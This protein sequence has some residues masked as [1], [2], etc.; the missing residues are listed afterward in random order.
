VEFRGLPAGLSRALAMEHIILPRNRHE[1]IQ[2]LTV[3]RG[4]FAQ[5]RG[6]CVPGQGATLAARP[7]RVS[8]I[9]Y[10]DHGLAV[11]MSGA[12]FFLEQGKETPMR[13]TPF[14]IAAASML[15]MGAGFAY[16]QS[17]TTETTTW[18]NADGTVLR[19]ESTT[20]HY[21]AYVDPALRPDVGIQLPG[22]VALYP[23]P[24]TVV[25]PEAQS[26]GYAIVN[27]QPVVV[28]RTTRR[29]VHTWE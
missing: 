29:V 24:R 16:G 17:S 12:L 4:R 21:D 20:H 27:N 8:L 11:P 18:T 13:R 2:E 9:P 10:P 28:E 19:Q 1:P 14:I 3:P 22:N 15:M 26:Y 5:A 6:G 23:L 25:V 7:T